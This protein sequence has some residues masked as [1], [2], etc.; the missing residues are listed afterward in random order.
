[1]CIKIQHM[2][3]TTQRRNANI[4]SYWTLLQRVGRVQK[5]L[6]WFYAVLLWFDSLTMISCG[7]KRMGIFIVILQYKCVRNKFVYFVGLLSCI[8]VVNWWQFLVTKYTILLR[9]GKLVV[10]SLECPNSFYIGLHFD[11]KLSRRRKVVA[12]SKSSMLITDISC[13]ICS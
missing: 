11:N 8:G 10:N 12:F 3:K 5:W 1:M 6:T 9:F 2:Y 13:R 4:F 7:P